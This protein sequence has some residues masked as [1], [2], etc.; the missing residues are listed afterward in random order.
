MA[1]QARIEARQFH[2]LFQTEDGKS[3]MEVLM[4]DFGWNSSAPPANKDGE[5]PIGR[6]RAW[7][8]SRSVI[9]T[10][11]HKCAQGEKLSDK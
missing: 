11:L 10:I 2:R 3:V 8:G 1:R 7:T 5:I 4:R 6:L 9:A